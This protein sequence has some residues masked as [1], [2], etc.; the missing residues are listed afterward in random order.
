[1]EIRYKTKQLKSICENL[2]KAKKEYGADV[3]EKLFS[4]IDFIEAATSVVDVKNY[5]PFHF[6][7]LKGKRKGEWAI[8]LGRKLGFRLIL[9]PIGKDGAACTND[10]VYAASAIEI[11][12]LQLEE[13]SNHYE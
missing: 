1:M 8:D 13:V 6:H 9:K 5:P 7:S 3:A 11:V 12:V 4:S 2:G 10:E